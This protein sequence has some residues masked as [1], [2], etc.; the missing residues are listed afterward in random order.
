MTFPQEL[1]NP[2]D[3]KKMLKAYQTDVNNY[4]KEKAAEVLQ[5]VSRRTKQFTDNVRLLVEKV[6]WSLVVYHKS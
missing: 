2:S 1:K 6:N 5:E 3:V 4:A